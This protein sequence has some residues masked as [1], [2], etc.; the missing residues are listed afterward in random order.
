[1]QTKDIKKEA[2]SRDKYPT[3]ET[4][5]EDLEASGLNISANLDDGGEF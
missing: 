5:S 4:L 2:Q 3:F 1:M